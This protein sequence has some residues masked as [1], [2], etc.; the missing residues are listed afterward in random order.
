MNTLLKHLYSILSVLLPLV[1]TL[2]GMAQSDTLVFSSGTKIIGEIKKME[3]GML[4][5]DA[6]DGDENFKI[7]W[8]Q[9]KRIQTSSVFLVS[10][11]TEIYE[12]Q[13]ESV[14]DDEVR[15]FDADTTYIV[16]P[17]KDI[18]YLKQFKEGFS[19]RFSAAA[20]LGFN[21][22]KAQDVRQFSL[23][24]SM[25]YKTSKSTVEASYNILRASQ[26]N[27]EPVKRTDGLL[28]YSRLLIKKWYGIASIYTL[29][30]TEQKIDLRANTQL[31]VG[32]YLYATNR[33]YWGLKAGVN[34]NLERFTNTGSN[35]NTWEAFYGTE[36]NLYDIQDFNLAFVFMGYSGM[37]E[38]GRF[39]A[40]TN[41]DIKYDLP[42]DLFIRIGFS[43]NYD[44]RP[45]LNAS[46]TD[47]ILRTGIGWEW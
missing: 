43:L 38:K 17:K 10:I 27:T 1:C 11:R 19:N 37:T 41:I 29:S 16:C 46:D 36:L 4:E 35:R 33:A 40:D 34:N 15:V 23:R 26:T 22:T 44:N 18:V 31:G 5:I 21:L 3:R 28:K 32:N 47:Y 39:R 12:G 42:W 6:L 13:I 25:G 7:K 9:I 14:S 30:N 8:L 24:S 20:E 45:A 2:K